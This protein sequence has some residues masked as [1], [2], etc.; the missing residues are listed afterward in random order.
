MLICALVFLD[1]ELNLIGS[2][3]LQTCPLCMVLFGALFVTA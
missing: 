1:S 3:R 2:I